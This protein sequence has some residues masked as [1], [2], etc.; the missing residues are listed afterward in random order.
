M[1]PVTLPLSCVHCGGAVT[2]EHEPPQR[3]D[4]I[5]RCAWQCPYCVKENSLELAAQFLRVT[6]G[7]RGG[8]DRATRR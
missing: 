6:P 1:E 4:V 5:H 3:G 7:H 8:S 2:L